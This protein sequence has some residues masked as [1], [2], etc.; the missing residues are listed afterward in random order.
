MSDVTKT[1][2]VEI[3]MDDGRVF[4]Y[5][6]ETADKVREHASAIIATG[7]R[8][9]DEKT[10]LWEW[11]PPYRILKIKSSNIPTFYYTKNVRGT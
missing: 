7:Y 9:S 5:E 4:S 10:G 2:P 6:V 8:H 11:Y 1:F 3:Y